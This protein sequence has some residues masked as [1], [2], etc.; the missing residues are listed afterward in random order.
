MKKGK[1]RRERAIEGEEEIYNQN[2]R[3]NVIGEEQKRCLRKKEK[4][5]EQKRREGEGESEKESVTE[6]NKEGDE[7]G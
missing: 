6:R 2:K 1:E 7:E 3:K 4:E 5:R